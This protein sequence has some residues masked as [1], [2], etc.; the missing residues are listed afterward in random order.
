MAAAIET[1]KLRVVYSPGLLKRKKVGLAGLD[2]R[3]DENELVGYLGENGSGKTTTIKALVGLIPPSGGSARIFGLDVR[4]PRARRA[5]GYMPENPYFYEHLSG[6]ETLDFYGRLLGVGRAERRARAGELLDRFG[7]A[8]AAR[9]RVRGYSKG[10]VQ[11]L[12]LAQAVLARPRLA[13]LDEPMTGLDPVGRFDVRQAI[14]EMREGGTTVFFSSH[15]LADVEAICDRVVM[16][17]RGR[18]VAQGRLEDLLSQRT[19]AVELAA[20]GVTAAGVRGVGAEGELAACRRVRE[21]GKRLYLTA[22]D[23]E[24]ANRL[25]E[26]IRRA[27]G[28]LELFAPAR[29]SLEEH[30]FRVREAEEKGDAHGRAEALP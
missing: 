9:E 7:L 27:G 22:P 26:A 30:F 28:S 21:E 15:I 14:A 18:V 25:V 3:V 11:R 16:L 23:E 17:H 24:A 4:A 8:H 10:M 1:E 20:R 5:L 6:L 2:L 19:K 29:E 12:G 13:I